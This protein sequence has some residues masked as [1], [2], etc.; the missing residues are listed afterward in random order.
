MQPTGLHSRIRPKLP[1][2]VASMTII[3][4]ITRYKT[5]RITF[6]LLGASI[7]R[8]IGTPG[9]PLFTVSGGGITSGRKNVSSNATAQECQNSK[10]MPYLLNKDAPRM[11]KCRC[12]KVKTPELEEVGM[13]AMSRL[14]IA[15]TTPPVTH[16][17]IFHDQR[18][19]NGIECHAHN[20]HRRAKP[21][22]HIGGMISNES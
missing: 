1:G 14:E 10:R 9:M 3:R 17:I 19:V 4:K 13:D 7:M 15:P 16:D 20:N 6:R 2:L 18:P 8:S 11:R 5:Q 12:Q 21:R 22:V